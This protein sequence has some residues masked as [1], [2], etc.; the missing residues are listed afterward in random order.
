[1]EFHK[2]TQMAI[3]SRSLNFILIFVWSVHENFTYNLF[4]YFFCNRNY[5]FYRFKIHT[6]RLI[7]FC[8]QIIDSGIDSNHLDDLFFGI[9]VDL[10]VWPNK[11][12][13]ED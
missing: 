3:Y 1:M 6:Y 13:I 12:N 10:N 4:Q 8:K 7:V 11:L 9:Y 2:Q 5:F